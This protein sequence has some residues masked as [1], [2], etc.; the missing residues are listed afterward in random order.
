LCLLFYFLHGVIGMIMHETM[1]LALGRGELFSGAAQGA[2]C[3][4]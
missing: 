3:G 1:A 2:V 4:V